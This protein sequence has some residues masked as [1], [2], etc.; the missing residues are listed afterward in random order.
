MTQHCGVC[1]AAVWR[2][3]RSRSVASALCSSQ[4]Y[5]QVYLLAVNRDA[6]PGFWL[7]T[8]AALAELAK[9]PAAAVSG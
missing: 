8:E 9:R 6:P 4:T 1:E 3:A 2:R 7:S 5:Q